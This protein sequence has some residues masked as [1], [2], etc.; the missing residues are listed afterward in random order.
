MHGISEIAFAKRAGDLPQ[1]NAKGISSAEFTI[2]LVQ[3]LG[4]T[5][6]SLPILF[7]PR[8]TPNT[9]PSMLFTAL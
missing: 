7:N 4:Q 8:P 6:V 9:N 3:N 2:S 5:R 1:K